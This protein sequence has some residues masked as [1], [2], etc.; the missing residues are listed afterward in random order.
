VVTTASGGERAGCLVGFQAQS[1]IE[2]ARFTVWLSKA[3]HT[4]R[5]A[6]HADHLAVHFLAAGDVGVAELFGTLTG[7]RVDKFTRCP[8]RP[9]PSGVPLLDRCPHRLVLARHVVLDEG[10]D[11]VAFVGRPVEVAAAGPF[12]PLRM[13]AV[14]HLAP[15]H[16]AGERPEP[17]I[18]RAPG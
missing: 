16:P 18:E 5:V 11:H 3:N 17:P 1:S 7:D 9:G 15:G 12:T 8:W 2:P 14:R 13:A 6:L 10:G 4:Y